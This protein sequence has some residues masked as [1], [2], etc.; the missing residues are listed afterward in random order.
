MSASPTRAS[1]SRPRSSASRRG[2]PVHDPRRQRDVGQRG[3][4]REQVERLE[5]HAHRLPRAA[6]ASIARVADVAAVEQDLAVVDV[7]E[8]VDAPQQRRL[9]RP[10]RADQ[11]DDLVLGDVEVDAVEHRAVVR[12]A[13]TQAPH[14]QHRC[15]RHSAPCRVADAPGRPV[16]EPCRRHRQRDEQ[17]AGHDVRG[18][19][20]GRG[21]LDLRGADGVDGAEH[22]DQPAVLLQRHEVVEQRRASPGGRPAAAP[23]AAWSAGG[24]AQATWRRPAA[25]DGPT[26]CP[27]GTPRPRRR[28]RSSTSAR[29]PSST[30]LVG[31]PDSRSPGRPNPTRY[32][33]ISSGRPRNRST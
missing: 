29:P 27:R 2:E 14:R 1:S 20:V 23:P 10:G 4:V 13:L 30:G 15:G 16:G 11:H 24:S 33:Q 8:Q 7:L 25:T 3:H 19:V 6:S 9:A 32:R 18:E 26:R 21:G 12:S 17:Q 22:R 31:T 5:H 28:S